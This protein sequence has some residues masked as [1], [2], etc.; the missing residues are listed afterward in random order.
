L[1][2]VF[3]Y[4]RAIVDPKDSNIVF[5]AKLTRTQQDIGEAADVAP[6]PVRRGEYRYNRTLPLIFSPLDPHILY[7]GANVL[8]K[9]TDQGRRWTIISPDLTRESYE[10]PANLGPFAAGDA[11]KGKHRG[12]IYA[13]APSF[14]E[15]DTI[16]AGTD[17]GLIQMSRDGGKTWKNVTPPALKP[18]AKVSIL[19]ASHFD[20]G[21]VYAAINTFRLDD[22]RPH[23]F[24]TRDYGVT[25]QEIVAGLPTNAPT[26]VV[27]ED[28]QRKGLL[29]AGTENSVYV[30]FNE[31]DSWQSLQLNLPHTSMRDLIIHGDDLVVATHG[32]SFW[33]LDDIAP[34]RQLS[35]KLALQPVI[36]FPPQTALRWRWNRNPDTPLPPEVPAG[37]NPPDGAIIDYYLAADAQ[38]PVTLE[39]LDSSG[40]VVRRY[41]STDKPPSMEKL[42]A[43]YP[44]PMYWVR[45]TPILSAGAGMHRFVWNVHCAQ[46]DALEREFPISAIV[47]N[48]PLGPLGAWALPGAYTVKLTVNGQSYSQPLKLKMDPRIETSIEDLQKQHEMQMGA[49]EGMDDTFE[50]L[51]QVK[52]VREQIQELSKEARGKEKLAKGLT[53]LD[54]QCAELE[55]GKQH[56]FYGVPSS[57]TPPE[58]LSTLNQHF[59]ALLAVADSAD[60]APTTQATAAYQDLEQ[61]ETAL[62]RR[63]STVCERDIPDLNRQLTKNGLAP[64]DPNKPLEQEL[65]G[66]SDGDDEP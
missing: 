58:N 56:S 39:I 63:W 59:A 50:S 54:N 13:V 33:I 35:D 49:V 42:A 57:G 64:L 18:W 47:H 53:A 36:L 12:T 9:T 37:A 41:A 52:S 3:E 31:G 7:F 66:A 32:R 38:G 46:P 62:R 51:E 8:F 30:S 19:E 43:T 44:I 48:T 2:G 14:K 27:R 16:W 28:P 6:E 5:G 24:R 20:A 45:P 60:A 11:E 40:A 4:G 17:D 55:G 34:L 23:I 26:D 1:P 22:L 65:G 10:I 21:T 61:S 29:F 25:W 15:V